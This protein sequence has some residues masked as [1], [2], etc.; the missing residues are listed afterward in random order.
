M[1]PLDVHCRPENGSDSKKE[2]TAPSAIPRTSQEDV[3]VQP[4]GEY[5]TQSAIFTAHSI[6]CISAT[7]PG[8]RAIS[9]YSVVLFQ[10]YRMV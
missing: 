3:S 7:G 10:L 2:L 5:Y 1:R 6:A 4:R 8:T 9:V